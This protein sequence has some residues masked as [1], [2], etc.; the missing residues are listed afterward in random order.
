M[1]TFIVYFKALFEEK[2]FLALVAFFFLLGVFNVSVSSQFQFQHNFSRIKYFRRTFS[3]FMMSQQIVSPV[4]LY[5]TLITLKYDFQ[6]FLIFGIA[7]FHV[8]A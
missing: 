1:C 4:E 3:A 7:S 2:G 8:P 6:V 5:N